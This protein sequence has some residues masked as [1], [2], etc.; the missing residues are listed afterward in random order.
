MGL[1]LFSVHKKAA[2]ESLRTFFLGPKSQAMI[3]QEY[4]SVYQTET[5]L[6][7]GIT[8]P[9]YTDPRRNRFQVDTNPFRYIHV[10]VMH[11]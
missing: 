6:K 9:I 8:V 10:R 2:S 4:N 11:Y 7:N 5:D 1:Y 3:Q